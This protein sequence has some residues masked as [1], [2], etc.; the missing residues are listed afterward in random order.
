M[1]IAETAMTEMPESCVK[2]DLFRISILYCPA[3]IRWFGVED[4]GWMKQGIPNWCPLR[5]VELKEVQVIENE[6]ESKRD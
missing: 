6:G 4:M 5:E 2:C 3:K 1:I